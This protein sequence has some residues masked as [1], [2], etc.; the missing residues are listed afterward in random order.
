MALISEADWEATAI[1]VLAEQGWG[2]KTGAEV[3]GERSSSADLIL[4]DRVQAAVRQLNPSV[5]EVYLRQAVTEILTPASQDAISENRRLHEFLVHGYRGVTW[6]DHD[7]VEQNPTIRLIGSQPA[8][9]DWLAVRQVK[10]A[11][12]EHHR[13]FDIVCYLNGLPVIIVELKQ[14]GLVNATLAGAHAQLGT[15][16]AEFPLAFRACV[17]TVISDGI[18]ASLPAGQNQATPAQT[19]VPARPD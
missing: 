9:N 6:I 3:A 8:D 17:A 1:E 7:G 2:A 13:R 15:Y 10:I 19:Q 4:T 14:A 16:L 11:N 12:A 5:P 18:T